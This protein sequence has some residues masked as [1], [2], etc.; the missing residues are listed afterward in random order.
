MPSRRL[1]RANGHGWFPPGHPR[2]STARPV[3]D[4]SYS[5]IGLRN[6]TRLVMAAEPRNR[7][8]FAEQAR[9]ALTH[10]KT[11]L[12]S[13]QH[14][15]RLTLVTVFLKYPEDRLPAQAMLTEDPGMGMPLVSYVFQ[16]PCSGADIAIEAWAIGGTGAQ[17]ERHGP[18]V[19]SISS[20]GV[21]WIYTAGIYVP[22]H[23]HSAYDQS[24]V[25]FGAMHDAL[26]QAGSHFGEVVRTWLYLGGITERDHAAEHYQELNR[27]RTDFFASVDFKNRRVNHTRRTGSFPASTGIGMNGRGLVVSSIAL[28]T[29]REDVR[30]V[31]LENPLQTPSYFYSKR[32]SPKS[33]KF[34]RAVALLLGDYMTTWISGTASIVNSETCHAGDIEGQTRQTLDNIERLISPENFVRSGLEKAGATLQ[35]LARVR[36]YIKR[37]EDFATC[38]RICEQ[39]LGS[40]PTVYVT[41]DICRPDLLVEIEGVA[42]SP[43][44]AIRANTD[45]VEFK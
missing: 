39:R 10:L 8:S 18:H 4:Q 28:H 26:R 23:G 3:E 9:E 19:L 20:D 7:G 24:L 41:A 16:P 13:Q 40:V 31:G 17:L 12:K 21:R 30:L 32:Y 22:D 1:L 25:A 35:D 37:P 15:M 43:L 34:S 42:L 14:S 44:P 45:G 5:V 27:A 11:I 2:R 38:R 36:V 33:P 29:D 6:V